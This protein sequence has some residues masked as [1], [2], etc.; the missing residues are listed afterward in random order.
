M[1]SRVLVDNVITIPLFF[2][3][4]I[5]N[6]F[7]RSYIISLSLIMKSLQAQYYPPGVHSKYLPKEMHNLRIGYNQYEG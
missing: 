2:L 1:L 3:V 5:F 7:I 4:G 6:V